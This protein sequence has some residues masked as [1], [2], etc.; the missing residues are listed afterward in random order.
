MSFLEIPD[1]LLVIIVEE[2]WDCAGLIC[3]VDKRLCGVVK[4]KGLYR[5][6]RVCSACAF[7]SLSCLQYFEKDRL[8]SVLIQD[9]TLTKMLGTLQYTEYARGACFLHGPVEV[10]EA[11][12]GSSWVSMATKMLSSNRVDLLEICRGEE[13]LDAQIRALRNGPHAPFTGCKAE[14]LLHA[15]CLA[16]T[17]EPMEYLWAMCIGHVKQFNMWFN[18]E[19]HFVRRIVRRMILLAGRSHA[20]GEIAAFIVSRMTD[21]SSNPRATNKA[22]KIVAGGMHNLCTSLSKSAWEWIINS[23]KRLGVSVRQLVDE[24]GASGLWHVVAAGE[25]RYRD[26]E[27]FEFCAE[28]MKEWPMDDYYGKIP[29]CLTGVGMS[30]L[31][32]LV[33][34]FTSGWAGS[35]L[36]MQ[37]SEQNAMLLHACAWKA[38]LEVEDADVHPPYF[39]QRV[40]HSL[41]NLSTVA[42][43]RLCMRAAKHTRSGLLA[44]KVDVVLYDSGFLYETLLRCAALNMSTAM[45]E[46]TQPHSVINFG[47]FTKDQLVSITR[48]TVM[49]MKPDQLRYICRVHAH[50]HESYVWE[51]ID[52]PTH[53]CEMFAI[54]L[55][56]FRQACYRRE[57]GLA[58]IASNSPAIVQVSLDH[59]CFLSGSL[60][61][62]RAFNILSTAPPTPKNKRRLPW[63][64]SR[65]KLAHVHFRP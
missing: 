19:H 40:F 30:T 35:S 47:R 28:S 57:G 21:T 58:A 33:K 42:A 3:V 49:A 62:T 44:S 64:P 51:A 65:S 4:R 18:I 10:I 59:K 46:A 24:Q 43:Y 55:Q 61:E 1:E 22:T 34:R 48:E 12:V 60:E 13:P 37:L 45:D 8:L 54:V 20:A 14:T 63:P 39:T 15:A 31:Y 32:K 27:A 53:S 26:A 2:S 52:N 17:F 38:M 41:L 50:Y 25:P 6:L 7:Y 23:C 36:F 11:V 56:K 9:R 29:K 16:D 5:R